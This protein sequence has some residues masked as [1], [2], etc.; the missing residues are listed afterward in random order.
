[1]SR[2]LTHDEWMARYSSNIHKSLEILSQYDGQRNKIKVRCKTCGKI[3][4]TLPS[5][6]SSGCRCKNCSLVKTQEQ[7]LKELADCNNDITPLEKYVN[8]RTKIL[9]K[10]NKCGHIWKGVPTHLIRGHGCSKCAHNK[11]GFNKRLKEE[12]FIKQLKLKNPTVKYVR[13]YAGLKQKA[14]F[15][16]TVCGHVWNTTPDNVLVNKSGCPYCNMSHGERIIFDYLSVHNINF[17]PQKTFNNLLGLKGGKLSYD[18]YLQD[19]NILIEFQGKQHE[20]PTSLPFVARKE[21][22]AE[23]QFEI[24]KE[25]DRRKKQFAKDNHI[26]LLEIWYYEQNKIGEIL[27]EKLNINNIKEAV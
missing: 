9:V 4:Y 6:L 13:G 21:I 7:F 25:H 17:E 24:Q 18:F 5:V 19:F 1:M 3:Y 10:C 16:S 27:N 12:D 11:I 23:E 26:E 22:T 15:T 14:T 8:D 20:Q 2:K